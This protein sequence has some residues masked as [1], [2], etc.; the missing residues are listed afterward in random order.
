MKKPQRK[1]VE[2]QIR[3]IGGLPT[4]RFELNLIKNRIE[5]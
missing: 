1:G 5:I 4:K 3:L 2:W